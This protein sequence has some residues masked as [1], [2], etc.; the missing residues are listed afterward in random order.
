MCGPQ[1]DT[2][3]LT[4]G[5][6]TLTHLLGQIHTGHRQG[7]DA[8]FAA[9]EA[10]FFV[11]G[12]FDADASAV[13]TQGLGDALFHFLNMGN[14]FGRLGNEGRIHID[15]SAPVP[16]DLAGGFLQENAAGHRLPARIGIGKEVADVGLAQGAQ[17][18]ITNCVHQ[19][20]RIGV[21]LESFR[22]WNFDAAEDEFSAGGECMHIITDTNMNHAGSV[23]DGGIFTKQFI[24]GTLV[25]TRIFEQEVGAPWGGVGILTHRC[26]VR[27]VHQGFG[28][29][30]VL[31]AF[32]WAR[33]KRSA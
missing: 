13:G 6:L 3:H 22:V 10:H 25:C 12:G 1:A 11:R 20:I 31:L 4:P 9:D 2:W 16:L 32:S 33:G 26:A 19:D 14:D 7:G 15:E 17:N 23:G 24:A 28:V 30:T 5:T 27:A 29:C 8:L 18:G 21:S